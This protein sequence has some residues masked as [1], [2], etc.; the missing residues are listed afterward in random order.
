KT[1]DKVAE[2]IDYA[3]EQPTSAITPVD[4]WAHFDPPELPAGLLPEPIEKFARVEGEMTGADPAG[5]AM[6]ALTACAAATPDF[7]VIN[8]K[9][10]DDAW[11]ESARLW[12]MLIGDP[13]TRKSVIIRIAAR[14]INAVDRAMAQQYECER[15]EYEALSAEERRTRERPRKR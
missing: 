4:L 5:F 10:H 8:P 1:G 7:V 13:S 3:G 14:P 6:A 12:T 2:I 15:Q 9:K 11:E